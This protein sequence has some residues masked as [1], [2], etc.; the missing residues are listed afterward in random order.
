[1]PILS[2][3]DLYF[4]FKAS[5]TYGFFRLFQTIFSSMYKF[6]ATLDPTYLPGVATSGVRAILP[7]GVYLILQLVDFIAVTEHM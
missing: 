5:T 7:D 4:I 1:M 3:V 6:L 2:L